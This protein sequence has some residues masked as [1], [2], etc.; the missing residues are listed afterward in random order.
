MASGTQ[1]LPPAACN[2]TQNKKITGN[3]RGRD[4]FASHLLSS[5]I[6]LLYNYQYKNYIIEIEFYCSEYYSE[7]TIKNLEK[8]DNNFTF[9]EATGL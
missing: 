5:G 8:M 6:I 2:K 3:E 7:V 4:D 9:M 1:N